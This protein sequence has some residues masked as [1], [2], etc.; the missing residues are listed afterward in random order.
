MIDLSQLE[1]VKTPSDIE[2]ENAKAAAKKYLSDT[3]F[4]IIRNLE[5]GKEV[6]AEVQEGRKNARAILDK[7]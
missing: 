4:Y 5:T 6:P 2:T 7:Q 1:K 3:D